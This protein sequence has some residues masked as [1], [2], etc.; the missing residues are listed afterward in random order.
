MNFPRTTVGG[1]SLPRMLIGCNWIS[2]FS[3]RSAAGDTMI[4]KAHR[5]PASTAAI[6]QTFM[7]SGVV[8]VLGLFGVD[9]NLSK[10]VKMAE[11][12][13]GKQMIIVDT[14]VLNMDDT[15]TARHEAELEIKASA[16]RGATF[17]LPLHSSVEQLINKNT[18]TMDRLPDYLRMIRDAGMIPGLSAHMPEVIQ[19]ADKND[20]DVETYIQPY[21]CMGFMMQVE[22]ESVSK[23]IHAARKPVITI[24]PCAAGR[25]TPYVGLNFV[26]N[27]I[28]EQDMVAIGCFNENEAAEDLEIAMAAIERRPPDISNRNSPFVTGVIK[29]TVS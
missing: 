27:T 3:H 15:A 16:A 17:C 6:F 18:E 21:N 22:I 26:Y 5:D 23:I 11:D 4:R 28:R 12:A 2:G 9:A 10:A 29:G 24:K 25:T 13:T 19:Y 8:A 7:N 1:I 20:Y 14:L